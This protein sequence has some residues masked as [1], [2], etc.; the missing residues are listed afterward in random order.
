MKLAYTFQPNNMTN[1]SALVKELKSRQPRII[2][3]DGSLGVGKTS[4]ARKIAKQLHC[5]CLHLDSFLIVGQGSFMPSLRY[6]RLHSAI[7]REKKMLVIEGICLMAVLER[8]SVAP[9]YLVFVD[10]GPWF[11]KE[12]KSD[13]LK[14]E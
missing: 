10:A 2:G 13:L 3:V 1:I 5:V 14:K 4:L 6:E 8:L 7:A 12:K 9:D 11:D